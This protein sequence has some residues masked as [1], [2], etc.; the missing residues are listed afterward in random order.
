MIRS[1]GKKYG[2]AILIE[3]RARFIAD[4]RTRTN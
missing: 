2:V 3:R 1:S 4:K